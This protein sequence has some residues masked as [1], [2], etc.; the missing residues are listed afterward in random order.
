LVLNREEREEGRFN[1][2][3]PRF[4]RRRSPGS[5]LGGTHG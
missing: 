2:L 1:W 5:K 4:G 3:S